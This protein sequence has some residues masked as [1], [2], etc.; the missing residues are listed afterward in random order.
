MKTPPSK[1]PATLETAKTAPKDPKSAGCKRKQRGQDQQRGIGA[2]MRN[3]HG[4]RGG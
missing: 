3:V 2:E 1:G 4:L